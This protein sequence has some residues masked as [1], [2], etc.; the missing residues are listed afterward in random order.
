MICR[1]HGAPASPPARPTERAGKKP[2]ILVVDDEACVRNLLRV[3][4]ERHGLRVWVA[5]DGREAVNLY[6]RRQFEIALVLLDVRMP[7]LDGPA[8]LAILRRIN[9]TVMCCLLS[10][11]A[12]ECENGRWPARVI[13]KP[14][15]LAELVALSKGAAVGRATRTALYA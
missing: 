10:G 3:V 14:F 4:L 12:A 2:G 11:N 6:C 1:I 5:A 9:P 8:T 7:V 15:H 13:A